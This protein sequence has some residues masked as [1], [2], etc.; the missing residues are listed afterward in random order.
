MYY[1]V[2]E[3]HTH[4]SSSSTHLLIPRIMAQLRP[5]QRTPISPFINFSVKNETPL[6]AQE[7][8][9]R[10]ST[11]SSDVLNMQQ[12]DALSMS[13][14]LGEETMTARWHKDSSEMVQRNS[15]QDPEECLK[16][17]RTSNTQA[18]ISSLEA[19][20]YPQIIYMLQIIFL[21][22]LLTEAL[23]AHLGHC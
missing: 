10:V 3:S 18:P 12:T 4:K 1:C 15:M 19:S 23:R 14:P 17:S 21:F 5:L 9:P 11:S 6:P 20:I 2:P 13:T 8:G 16:P 22:C 7:P